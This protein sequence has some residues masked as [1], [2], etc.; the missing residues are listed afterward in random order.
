MSDYA[1]DLHLEGEEIEMFDLDNMSLTTRYL[2]RGELLPTAKK[3][4][5][6]NSSSTTTAQGPA[7]LETGLKYIK[8]TLKSAVTV[9]KMEV[10][11]EVPG[12]HRLATLL[13][14]ISR[15]LDGL[16]L[17]KEGKPTSLAFS[18]SQKK[19]KSNEPEK[20]AI[21]DAITDIILIPSWWDSDAVFEADLAKKKRR[22]VRK[23]Q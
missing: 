17:T 23:P 15:I 5:I 13:A 7:D 8:S 18:P 2:V 21:S 19:A 20:P 11:K 1:N 22:S 16:L 14:E 3:R 10:V 12:M 9:T 4:K 6:E